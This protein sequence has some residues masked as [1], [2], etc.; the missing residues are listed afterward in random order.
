MCVCVCVCVHARVCVSVRGEAGREG[1]LEFSEMGWG[2][3][4]GFVFEM[5]G[6]NPLG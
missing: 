4:V 5:G 6:F 1:V 2:G 3:G